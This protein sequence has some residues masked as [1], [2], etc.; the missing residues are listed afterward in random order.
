MNVQR[1]F[2]KVPLQGGPTQAQANYD[3]PIANSVGQAAN[4]ASQFLNKYQ[5]AQFETNKTNTVLEVQ[6]SINAWQEKRR[7]DPILP[8]GDEDIVALKEQDWQE[9]SREQVRSNILGKIQDPRLKD[10]MNTWWDEQDERY[11]ATV[12]ESAMDENINYMAQRANEDIQTFIY[13]GQYA[14]AMTRADGALESGLITR[15]QHDEVKDQVQLQTVLSVTDD[16][17]I[18]EAEQAINESNLEAD[19]KILAQKYMTDRKKVKAE[20]IKNTVEYYNA[21]SFLD[22]YTAAKEGTINS[23]EQYND[24]IDRLP[25]AKDPE[26][27][28][29]EG[30]SVLFGAKHVKEIMKLIDD[31][32]KPKATTRS[33][34]LSDEVKREALSMFATASREE[35]LQYGVDNLDREGYGIEFY[36]YLIDEMKDPKY[37]RLN[38]RTDYFYKIGEKDLLDGGFISEDERAVTYERY[39]SWMQRYSDEEIMTESYMNDLPDF[40]RSMKAEK[41]KYDLSKLQQYIAEPNG[42][43]HYSVAE[44][45]A[46]RGELGD[47][48]N[49]TDPEVLGMYMSGSINKDQFLDKISDSLYSKPFNSLD[50]KDKENRVKLS[51]AISEYSKSVERYAQ[52]TLPKG[53]I[54]MGIDLRTNLPIVLLTDPDGN[55]SQYK[56]RVNTTTKEEEWWMWATTPENPDPDWYPTGIELKSTPKGPSPVTVLGRTITTL[57]DSIVPEVENTPEVE[58]ARQRYPGIPGF[59]EPKRSYSYKDYYGY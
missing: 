53:D 12:V 22:L 45:L 38:D 14:L 15:N 27:G 11:R 19:Q 25:D 10:Y 40:F 16:M 48:L 59:S 30:T 29:V 35:I 43:G 33:E 24:Y 9:F 58:A 47:F 20:S 37:K 41:T 42:E 4:I 23:I 3:T 39:M 6:K 44:K 36:D 13:N 2:D 26:Y 21:A 46:M 50:N 55:V 7:T 57:L 52:D 49:Q 8:Q 32:N 51:L 54:E 1:Y 18:E 31:R 17:T 34:G 56:L 28:V 5:Q